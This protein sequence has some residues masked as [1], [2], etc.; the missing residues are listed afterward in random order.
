MGRKLLLHTFLNILF[1]FITTSLTMLNISSP[2]WMFTQDF[3]NNYYVFHCWSFCPATNISDHSMH[4]SSWKW[5]SSFLLFNI[6]RMIWYA[7]KTEVL[8]KISSDIFISQYSCFKGICLN[9]AIF[10]SK[11]PWYLSVGKWADTSSG[12]AQEI[13][14]I[15]SN[16]R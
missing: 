12:Y 2:F 4:H 8:D 11:V 9:A 14:Y 15:L 16:P 6:V 5:V 1:I 3:V 13:T 7:D 10:I